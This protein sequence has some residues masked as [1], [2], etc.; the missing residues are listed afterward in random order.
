MPAS[1]E[2][3]SRDSFASRSDRR[4]GSR[5]CPRTRLGQRT[6]RG[7]GALELA[8]A[9]TVPPPRRSRRSAATQSSPESVPAVDR[10]ST[11]PRQS[12]SWSRLVQ[13]TARGLAKEAAHPQR[14][15]PPRGSRRHGGFHEAGGGGPARTRMRSLL[16]SSAR[17]HCRTRGDGHGDRKKQRNRVRFTQPVRDGAALSVP[18]GDA[19]AACQGKPGDQNDH[20]GVHGSGRRGEPQGP[21]A[22]TSRHKTKIVRS[23]LQHGFRF[24]A[25]AAS[26]ARSPI[27]RPRSRIGSPGGA[28][29]A[30]SLARR[31]RRGCRP[32]LR[33]GS[34][35][36][37]CR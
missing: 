29:W 9:P 25:R 18:A 4:G 34:G 3:V 10:T 20:A 31:A 33:A 19:L 26:V 1:S 7:R 32:G 5:P 8:W 13:S 23:R 15:H 28:R 30:P 27:A 16:R 12:R 22:R 35:C 11:L 21:S 6:P 24:E 37:P 36:H 2:S 14:R 17:S